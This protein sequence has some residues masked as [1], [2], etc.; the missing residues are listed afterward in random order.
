VPVQRKSGCLFRIAIL[1]AAALVPTLDLKAAHVGND[2]TLNELA[3]NGAIAFVAAA[4]T[5]HLDYGAFYK[6]LPHEEAYQR[7]RRIL[8]QKQTQFEGEE[9]RSAGG[10]PVK[11]P[12][13]LER[14]NFPRRKSRLRILGLPGPSKNLTPEM[15]K[16]AADEGMLFTNIYACGNRTVRGMKESC[17]LSHRCPATRSSNAIFP[18]MWRPSPGSKARRLLDGFRYGGRG[19]SMA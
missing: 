2:R 18:T 7:V 16:L 17:L 3:N 15:D 5:R 14:G 1:L 4:R 10:W 8:A 11:P 9:R 12:A 19:I 13:S 6:T